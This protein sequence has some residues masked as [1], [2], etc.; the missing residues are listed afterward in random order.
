MIHRD[1]TFGTPEEDAFR[2]DFTINGMFYDIATFSL[3]DYVGGLDDL[4]QRLIR[5][6]GDPKP[7][8][9]WKIPVRM[10]RPPFAARLDLT[11]TNWCRRDRAAPRADPE[12]LPARLLEEGISRFCDPAMPGELPRA[13]QRPVAGVGDPELKSPPDAVWESLAR[14]GSK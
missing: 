12:G 6:I 5:S 7:C 11:C 4:E 13:R 10:L 14:A 1:N 3:I 2:R 9:S 8:A